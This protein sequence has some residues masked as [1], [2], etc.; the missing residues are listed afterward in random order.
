MRV[1]KGQVVGGRIVVEDEPLTE[2]AAVPVLFPDEQTFTLSD[3]NEEDLLKS[4][5][6]ADRGDLL[7]VE[8]VLRRLPQNPRFCGSRSPLSPIDGYRG[9]PV[10]GRRTDRKLP[11][12]LDM[13]LAS[14]RHRSA[15]RVQSVR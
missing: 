3:E 4:I 13:A 2:G 12:C 1:T 5:A 11:R 9:W 7:D 10:G 6:E 8:D 15:G 14:H